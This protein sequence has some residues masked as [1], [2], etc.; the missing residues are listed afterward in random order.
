M[1][2]QPMANALIIEVFAGTSRVTASLRHFGMFNCFGVDHL[3]A[4]NVAA[5]VSIADLTSAEGIA[6]LY[7][8]LDNPAVVGIFLAPPCGTASRARNIPL[9][10]KRKAPEPLRDD[11]NP[12]G[13]KNLKWLD[14][15]K[16]SKSNKLYHLT[17]ELVLYA[18][19]HGL[20]VCVENP[21]FSLFWCTTF[22]LR[23]SRKVMYT[24]FH[25]CQYGSRR[26]KKTMLAHNYH[27]FAELNLQCPGESKSHSHA[28][29]GLSKGRFAT[30]EETA[31]PFPLARC[32]A[33]AFAKA[34]LECGLVAPPDTIHEI[35]PSSH[36]ILQAIRAQ[37]NLQPKASKLPPLVPEFKQI[38]SITG[39]QQHLPSPKTIRLDA[40]LSLHQTIK[41]SVSKLPES[42]KLLKTGSIVAGSMKGGLSVESSSS[43]EKPGSVAVLEQKWGVPWS[44]EE[45]VSQA[46][47]AGHPC[48]LRS[49][50]PEVLQQ[51]VLSYGSVSA[52]ARSGMRL[53]KIKYWVDTLHKLRPD[54]IKFK[55]SL[56]PHVKRVLQNKNLLLYK[57]LLEQCNY[58][59]MGVFREFVS[60]TTLVGDSE[61][62]GLWPV[63]HTPN[64]CTASDLKSMSA[65]D[66]Q[67]SLQ[68]IVQRLDTS[69]AQHVWE[70]TLKEVEKGF[71]VGPMDP[72]SVDTTCPLSPRFGIIQG[73]KVR[74]IDDFSR[75]G[76]NAAVRTHESPR[77]HTIDVVSGLALLIMSSSCSSSKW[78][79]RGFDLKDA[80][81]QCAVHPDSL[82]YSHIVVVDP[83]R[84]R[85]FV[86]QMV[87]LPFGSIKSVHGFLRVAHSIWYIAVHQ[88]RILWTNYFDDYVTMC[89]SEEATQTTQVVH[90]LLDLLG[91]SFAR[92]GSK[93]PP[94]SDVC[95]A[96]GV[97]I[98]VSG[99]HQGILTV[100]NS[101]K[102]KKELSS[103]ISG[104]LTSGRLTTCDA[105]RLRGRMQFASGQLYGRA[106]R[107]CMAQVTNH[108]YTPGCTQVSRELAHSL[109]RY[110]AA[111]L[112]ERPRTVLKAT[113]DTWFLFT[114]AS[115]E[116][117]GEA[118]KA[119][120]GGLIVDPRGRFLEFFQFELCNSQLD[121]LNPSGRK[122]VIFE[123]EFLAL[124]IALQTWGPRLK[125][126]QLV[127]YIDNNSVRDA[128]ISCSTSNKVG[129]VI[130]SKCLHIEDEF[131]LQ[132]WFAR[133]PSPSNPADWPS[134]GSSKELR[135]LGCNQISVDVNNVLEQIKPFDKGG[136]NQA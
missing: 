105:L 71:L 53:A 24:V 100:D 68:S 22:W 98:N 72:L 23:V 82:A 74:C 6:L 3:R 45:F 67:S 118:C 27:T 26:Q 40:A 75:S 60:G 108:A 33:H 95:S 43:L 78:V 1:K 15:L 16:I 85:P 109:E 91:W 102:R 20:I 135:K 121:V 62:T 131:Q 113:G 76:V 96:L 34:L 124:L 119:G 134:R 44:P 65:R 116:G 129:E 50:V 61:I 136:K 48:S 56:A 59:D 94:F 122:T 63:K 47:S 97:V 58:P 112:V 114:D 130:M 86:F 107:I 127:C 104:I 4:N 39:P 2:G 64:S 14:K 42:S 103:F 52:S 36:Q 46:V 37:G 57:H 31:Y 17:S 18:H 90:M 30:A 69:T 29:W 93:A 28:K 115:F 81:R 92:D 84:M 8:W 111:L 10:G 7:S 77:P 12:N 120:F 35:E 9:K 126:L 110:L 88:L 123:C 87:A 133:V 83:S 11:A 125:S 66:R 13:K 101:D 132:S 41:S 80:Y 38:V 19:K 70:Q 21:Q 117:E 32:I 89:P 73:E 54:E 55:N 5:P 128:T 79:S 51:A 106:V 99:L 25:S 49:F